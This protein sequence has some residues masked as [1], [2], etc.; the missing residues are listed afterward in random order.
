MATD[1]VF[2]D[3]GA[4]GC[5]VEDEVVRHIQRTKLSNVTT[6][7][8]MAAYMLFKRCVSSYIDLFVDE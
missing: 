4:G 3:S 6:P 8:F 7:T 1:Q 5:G 2:K